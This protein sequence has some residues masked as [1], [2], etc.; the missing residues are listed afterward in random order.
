M[1]LRR[2][3]MSDVLQPTQLIATLCDFYDA[4]VALR[5]GGRVESV[6]SVT[7][8]AG[9]VDNRIAHGL[10]GTLSAWEIIDKS[11]NADVWKSGTANADPTVILLRASAAVTVRLRFS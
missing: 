11:A 10:R 1:S 4:I 2:P 5:R 9:S 6:V 3:A 7:L 8:A